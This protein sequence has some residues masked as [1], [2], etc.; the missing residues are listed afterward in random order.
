MAFSPDG[1]R[2]AS[3]GSL[4][5]TVHLWDVATGQETFTLQGHTEDVTSVAFSPDGRRL[6]SASS[7]KT[8]RL[9]DLAT[10]QE[11]LALSGH[12]GTVTSVAFSP[13]GR[14][15]ASAGNDDTV[16][17]WDATVLTPQALVEREARGLL[18]FLSAKPLL[19]D[20]VPAAVRRDRTIREAVRQQALIWAQSWPED[21]DRL[22]GASWNVV[23]RQGAGPE[24]VR[25]A[26]RWAEAACRVEPENGNH[27]NTL[28]VA[29]YRAGQYA[30]A[31]A[32]LT[33]AEPLNVATYKGPTPAD[34]AFQAMAHYQLGHKD[35]AQV[36]LERLRAA[37]K[38]PQWAKDAEAEALFAGKKG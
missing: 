37:L 1:R 35:Q 7:D 9:W 27:L 16:R 15:L 26:L 2:L 19:A 11:T 3:A 23:R 10:G 14:R 32:T 21:A 36:A 30:A 12:T 29:Q 33:R 34:L 18:R 24:A 28:G 22:N 4:D 13:D 38:N 20:E 17:L 25:Q 5:H 31:L 6:A 8:V